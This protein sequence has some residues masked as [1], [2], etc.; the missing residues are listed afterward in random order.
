MQK[1]RARGKVVKDKPAEEL[2]D[3]TPPTKKQKVPGTKEAMQKW[4]AGAKIAE[5]HD[6]PANEHD[7]P[8]PPTKKQKTQATKKS[9]QNLKG[10]ASVKVA[11]KERKD[12][13]AK[14]VMMSKLRSPSPN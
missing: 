4:G 9:M 11:E 2:D 10:G 13:K 1:G 14:E 6:D 5:D 8:A 3:P 12:G 7:N